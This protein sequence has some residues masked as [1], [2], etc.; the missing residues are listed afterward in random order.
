MEDGLAEAID[1]GKV[2]PR[3]DPKTR[4]KLLVDEFGWDKVPILL[5]VLPSA[6]ASSSY[7]LAGRPPSG[8][9]RGCG[10]T[11]S[12]ASQLLPHTFCRGCGMQLPTSRA[13]CLALGMSRHLP[14]LLS[15]CHVATPQQELAK[16]IW[17]FGPDTIGPNLITDIS[18]GVQYLNEIKDS[19]VAAFQ[20]A[21]KEGVLCEENMRG[22]VF[23]VRH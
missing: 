13:V 18:K 8:R 4:G 10:R 21:S 5:F 3:D 16:K 6:S 20:W 22:V 11:V 1:E 19:C 7:L 17:A 15:P 9:G 14:P 12:P 2:G 23:E